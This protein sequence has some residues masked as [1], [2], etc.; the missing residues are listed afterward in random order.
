MFR[1][2][3][4]ALTFSALFLPSL[5][6]AATARAMKRETIRQMP[7]L[8]RPYRIGHIYGNTVRRMSK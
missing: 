1:S 7:I 8:E 4:I 5:A 6:Q 3:I 2:L